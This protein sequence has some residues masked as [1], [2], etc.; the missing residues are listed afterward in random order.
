MI[1]L[2]VVTQ[3]LEL[4][5]IKFVVSHVTCTMGVVSKNGLV[6]PFS[7]IILMTVDIT[8]QM[9]KFIYLIENPILSFYAIYTLIVVYLVGT[10]YQTSMLRL[11]SVLTTLS[12]EKQ[13]N[14]Q[15]LRAHTKPT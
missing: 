1:L 11:S 13:V 9:T 15:C 8:D 10:V 2:V 3:A 14:R 5:S 7:I 6:K 4:S 12:Y